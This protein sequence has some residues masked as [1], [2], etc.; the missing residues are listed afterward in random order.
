MRRYIVRA[1]RWVAP[2]DEEAPKIE[3]EPMQAMVPELTCYE[4]EDAVRNT[5]LV[6]QSGA[7]IYAVND[8]RM[9]YL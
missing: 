4:R 2:G 1:G 6:D 5:G 7:A 3:G 8:K 9:G